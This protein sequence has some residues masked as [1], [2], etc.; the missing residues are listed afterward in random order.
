MHSRRAPL[1]SFLFSLLLAPAL[2][3]AKPPVEPLERLAITPTDTAVVRVDSTVDRT[4]LIPTRKMRAA[5]SPAAQVAAK[6]H[7]AFAEAIRR[8][9][10]NV[11]VVATP[12]PSPD[13]AR[14]ELSLT[15]LTFS[16]ATVGVARR[17][18]PPTPPSYDPATGEM[19]PGER[20]GYA[21]GPGR[22]TTLTAQAQWVIRDRNTGV[23]AGKSGAARGAA[24]GSA[25]TRGEIGTSQW[26]EAAR[27]LAKDI[28]R[29]S[30]FAPF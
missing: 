7:P 24:S 4:G 22:E 8:A 13:S 23:P 10:R 20:K 2:L 28:L 5:P 25:S 17:F 29:Q 15:S 21:E 19:N 11:E 27:E 6:F 3:A 14:Y 1:H 30:N 16:Q 26:D 9:A 18:H 12:D